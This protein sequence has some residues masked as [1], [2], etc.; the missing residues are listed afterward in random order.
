MR[1]TVDIFEFSSQQGAT[2]FSTVMAATS[3]FFRDRDEVGRV[4]VLTGNV[5][6]TSFGTLFSLA[7]MNAFLPRVMRLFVLATVTLDMSRTLFAFLTTM[8][9]LRDRTTLLGNEDQFSVYMC[10]ATDTMSLQT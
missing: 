8:M 10:A 6:Q 4:F 5:T 9:T 7:K 1:Q 2:A 3:L